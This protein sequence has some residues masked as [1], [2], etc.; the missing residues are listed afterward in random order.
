MSD[1]ITVT[2]DH[3]G[4][5]IR[6]VKFVVDS[7]KRGKT[8]TYEAWLRNPI[9]NKIGDIKI[10]YFL[11]NLFLD[12]ERQIFARNGIYPNRVSRNSHK[13]PVMSEQEKDRLR[14]SVIIRQL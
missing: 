13:T 7:V 10:E 12:N 5:S 2:I 4:I 6:E 3:S 14:R 11:E 1:V 9:K 8:S